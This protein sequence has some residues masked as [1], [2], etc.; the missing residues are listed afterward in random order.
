[1]KFQQKT[2]ATALTLTFASLSGAAQA[3]GFALIEQ[4]ASGSGNA[5]AGG[6]AS[7]EDASTIFFNPAGMSR[8]SGKQL[9]VAGHALKLKADFADQGSTPT[10]T[11]PAGSG[12]ADAGGWAFVPAGHFVS[13]IT[14]DLHAGVG[15]FAPFGLKTEYPDGWIG[16]FQALKSSMETL[17]INPSM[18]YRVNDSL[19]IGAGVNYQTIKA[20]LTNARL[21]GS[22]VEGMSKMS[23]DDAAWGYNFGVLMNLD[24]NSRIG[25]SYRSS[26]NFKLK[27][28]VLVTAPTGA[29][30]A[31]VPV[32]ADFKTPDIWS[33]SYFRSVNEQWDVMADLTRTG[34][35][36]F[37]ELRIVDSS[38]ATLSL[39][40]ENWTNTWRAALGASYHYNPQWT[41][42]V[43]IAYDQTPMT[44]ATRTARIPDEDRRE[45][46]VGG[47]YKMDKTS[48]W[49]VSYAHLFVN[50]ASI[51]VDLSAAPAGHLVGSYS[52]SVD[53]ISLQYT[54]NF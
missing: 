31:D 8:L 37:Q 39:T 32:T 9:T 54:H 29:V 52:N 44:D 45:I 1:M 26:I 51:D 42:R 25:V 15:V 30:V 21:L 14:P 23:G 12:T 4:S 20:E 13:E 6:A 41:A 49:D 2:L 16:R 27:G 7:A 50:N 43:G 19:S 3:S 33:F 35:S 10:P 22:G 36:S 5:Y 48:T 11:V 47:Q 53:I 28:N 24:A 17:D 46:A 38:G 18:S 40:N 34:W